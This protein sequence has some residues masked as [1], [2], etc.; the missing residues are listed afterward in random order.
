MKH[1]RN[2]RDAMPRAV[3]MTLKG[4]RFISLGLGF[5]VLWSVQVVH[6]YDY[7]LTTEFERI[8]EH[9]HRW[10]MRD[11]QIMLAGRPAVSTYRPY[12]TNGVEHGLMQTIHSLSLAALITFI[13]CLP[14]YA[15]YLSVPFDDADQLYLPSVGPPIHYNLIHNLGVGNGA[16]P[17]VLDQPIKFTHPSN[18]A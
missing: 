1:K 7:H 13:C 12:E 18:W 16:D 14:C 4:S 5:L 10:L 2:V 8:T 15:I 3:R 9:A 11:K 17:H 6:G